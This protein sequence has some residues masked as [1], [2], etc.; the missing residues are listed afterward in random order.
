MMNM[1]WIHYR[2]L[3]VSLRSQGF[4]TPSANV[5]I[6]MANMDRLPDTPENHTVR[7]D[8]KAYLTAAMGQIVELAQR[9]RATASTSVTSS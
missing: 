7:E 8:I 6:V 5:A 9:A 2:T 4:R 3:W 1:I